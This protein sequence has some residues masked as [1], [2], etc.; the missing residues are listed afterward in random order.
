MSGGELSPRIERRIFIVGAPRSGTTLLQSLLAGHSLLTSFTESHFF[1]RFFNPL[2]GP[3]GALLGRFPLPRLR[4]FLAENEEDPPP[5][6]H[7]FEERGATLLARR[8]LLPFQTRKVARRL[9]QVLDELA[10]DRGRPGW[11]EKTPRHLHFLPLIERVAAPAGG[12]AFVHLVRDGL[13]VAASLHRASQSWERPYDLDTCVRRW[14]ADLRRSSARLGSPHDHFVVYEQLTADPEAVLRR[15]LA[16]LGLDWE[17]AILD[18]RADRADR[19]VTPEESWKEDVGRPIRPSSN[20]EQTL[21][22]EQRERV[23]A[24]LRPEPYRRICAA[25]AETTPTGAG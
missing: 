16:A 20:A 21:T 12:L 10:L 18:R 1:S 23:R 22:P 6:M 5:A 8:P 19:W 17:P 3:I 24:L 9:L 11:V 7:W 14:N 25:A 13:E 4:E 15:L 2:P